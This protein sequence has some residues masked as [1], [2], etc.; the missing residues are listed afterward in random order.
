MNVELDNLDKNLLN[1]TQAEFPLVREPFSALGLSLG[2]TGNE[3]IHRVDRLKASGIIRLIG[4]VFNPKK[5]GYQTTLVAAK[6]PAERLEKAGLIISRHQMVSHCYQRDHN[7]NL[8]FTLSL[9]VDRDMEDEVIELGNR[10]KSETTLNLPAIKTFKIGVY[11]APGDRNS[12]LSL[13]AK[14]GNLSLAPRH[15]N[16]L[17]AVDRAV[18]NALQQDLPL[19]D[20]PFDQI[21]TKM[22]MDADKFLSRCQTLLQ[23]G[24]MR[25]FS[26]S[27][28][29]YRLG[30]ISNAMVCWKV[31]SDIVDKTG[32]K[33]ATFP[34]VSHCYERRANRLWPYNLF[35]MTHAYS[36]E[37]CRAV[38]D[39]ICSE[40]GLNR[41]EMLLLFS[42]KEVKKTRVQYKV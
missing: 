15:N 34:E 30:Y 3:V 40:T 41:N 24:I 14:C 9:P 35:A 5:L 4:P 39:K 37:N 2:I 13:P 25:R 26:A 23:R 38:T 7:F 20:K 28:N 11:F 17:S 42:T 31:P 36:N 21:A 27:I 16:K 10:I 1:I 18:V 6:V 22:P 32:K 12:D 29:Q 33:I 8:W 19:I